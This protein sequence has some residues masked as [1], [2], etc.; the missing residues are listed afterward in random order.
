[1][2]HLGCSELSEF[3]DQ[4]INEMKRKSVTINPKVQ[5]GFRKSDRP[6]SA[7]KFRRK[8]AHSGCLHRNF[9]ALSGR[10]DFR[11]PFYTF[12]ICSYS[13]T[14][15]TGI[16]L[17]FWSE[18]L[19]SYFLSF[20]LSRGHIR[21]L[22]CSIYVKAITVVCLNPSARIQQ[23]LTSEFHHPTPEL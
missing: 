7:E 22:N 10:S 6:D 15:F 5:K 13:V 12:E 20:R 8:P 14:L 18:N 21:V 9:S 23:H 19:S 16:W 11:K 17:I 3:S 4:E 1:M 2:R